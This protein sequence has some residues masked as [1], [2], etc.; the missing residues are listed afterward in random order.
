MSTQIAEKTI[1]VGMTPPTVGEFIREEIL[2]GW[3]LTVEKAASALGVRRATL[4]DVV[5]G[6]AA[7]SPEMALRIELAFGMDMETLLRMQVWSDAVAWR[8]RAAVGWFDEIK[9]LSPP[10]GTG[11]RLAS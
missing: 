10:E 8:K 9:R 2:E 3:G 11:A 1:K 4:S 5:N 7:L 6:R